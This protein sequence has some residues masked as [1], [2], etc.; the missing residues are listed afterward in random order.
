MSRPLSP[1][2]SPSLF[3][4]L[5]ACFI[6]VPPLSNI[7]FCPFNIAQEVNSTLEF[8]LACLRCCPILNNSLLYVLWLK[9]RQ[10]KRVQGAQEEVTKPEGRTNKTQ[11]STDPDSSQYEISGPRQRCPVHKPL[12]NRP[13]SLTHT[14]LRFMCLAHTGSN[15][16]LTTENV[17]QPSVSTLS[18]IC[19][20]FTDSRDHM[21]CNMNNGNELIVLFISFTYTH[22]DVIF[23]CWTWMNTIKYTIA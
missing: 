4:I 5:L 1:A 15:Y 21:N 14:H 7:L 9:K 11:L 12:A 19:L 6:M 17:Y 8:T 23:S 3:A 10:E 13:S 16:L 20:W 22:L 2:R 18:L